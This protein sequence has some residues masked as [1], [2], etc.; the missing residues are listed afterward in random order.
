MWKRKKATL[1]ENTANF[2]PNFYHIFIYNLFEERNR[3]KRFLRVLLNSIISRYIK[4]L[5]KLSLFY[6]FILE[7]L[8]LKLHVCY[9]ITFNTMSQF[10]AISSGMEG[11]MRYFTELIDNVLDSK[12]EIEVQCRLMTTEKVIQTEP[13]MF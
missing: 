13:G 9:G 5:F 7:T 4:Q 1:R 8:I 11:L 6:H 3:G 10:S 2:E 12:T